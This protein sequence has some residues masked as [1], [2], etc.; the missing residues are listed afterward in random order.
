MTTAPTVTVKDSSQLAQGDIVR[1]HGMRVRLD[2]GAS[3]ER[4]DRTVYSWVGTVLNLDEVRANG[5]VPMSFL[6]TEKWEPAKGWVTDRKD[7]WV[8]QGNEFVNWLVED[9][10]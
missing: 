6:R 1:T 10:S 3:S 8:V 4:S 9:P 2:H 5:H 7:V